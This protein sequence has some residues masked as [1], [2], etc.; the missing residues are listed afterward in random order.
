[1]RIFELSRQSIIGFIKFILILMVCFFISPGTVNVTQ[2]G[3]SFNGISAAFAEDGD[4][5]PVDA[6]KG[7]NPDEKQADGENA[8][9]EEPPPCPECPDP[10]KVILKGLEE[11]KQQIAREEE[12]LKQERKELEKFKEEIDESLERLTALKK[13]IQEDLDS[14]QKKKNR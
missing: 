14:L 10:A 5:K 2:G 8:Q 4:E 9:G 12:Q 3:P 6:E 7:E 11:K 13:Q 1:M